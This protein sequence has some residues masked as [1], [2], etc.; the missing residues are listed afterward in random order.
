MDR[1]EAMRVFVE[2]ARQRSFVG[3]GRNLVLSAAT[4]SR[5]VAALEER[6]GTELFVRTTRTVRLS[7]AGERYLP[8]CERLLAEV[9]A[10][11]A[12]AAG[13]R[14]T[15]VGTLTVTA[16][17][18]F[19]RHY[20]APLVTE[21]CERHPDLDVRLLL[22]DRVTQ[23]V[24]EGIDVALRIG[25]LPDSSLR[26]IPVGTVRRVVAGSPAYLDRHGVPQTPDDLRAHRL[27]AATNAQS[28]VEWRFG[29]SEVI[30]VRVQ[31]RIRCNEIAAAIDMAESGWGLT[32]ALSYQVGPSLSAGR[33]RIVLE[34]FEEEPLPVHLVYGGGRATSAKV[35]AFLDLATERLRANPLFRSPAAG[36][37]ASGTPP[38]L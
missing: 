32:R 37:P 23:L 28:A 22:L 1:L 6:L 15:P 35:R 21:L 2:V 24:E 10:A 7:D 18:L 5:T 19:G 38:S 25:R 33:L 11:E 13:V 14:A 26:A 36:V 4:V 30:S 20:A 3:A 16:P 9:D 17:V 27:V 12:L 34:A 8:E 29:R 31:P